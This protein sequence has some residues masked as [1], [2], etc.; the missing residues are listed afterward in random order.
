MSRK[1]PTMFFSYKSLHIIVGR[2]VVFHAY[3]VLSSASLPSNPPLAAV[4]IINPQ[5]DVLFL[6][7]Y[8]SDLLACACVR[9]SFGSIYF[10][11]LYFRPSIPIDVGLR[12]LEIFLEATRGSTVYIGT[13][14]N[15]ESSLWSP[16][17]NLPSRGIT[18][19]DFIAS[20][21]LFVLNDPHAGD[22]PTYSSSLGESFIDVTL[23][24]SSAA[25]LVESWSIMSDSFTSDHHALD[26]RIATSSIH[27]PFEE[28]DFITPNPRVRYIFRFRPSSTTTYNR[29]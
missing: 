29:S 11:S 27:Q 21:G 15:A 22:L 18:M 20:H 13:D 24:S 5:L 25:R 1:I 17:G 3:R 14:A 4:V 10:V 23:A 8:S 28:E 19:T 6:P 12:R 2:C 26:I 9:G 16:R 7:Q